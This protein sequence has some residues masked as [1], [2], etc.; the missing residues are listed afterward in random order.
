MA[1]VISASEAHE[2]YMERMKAEFHGPRYNWLLEML[3]RSSD[4]GLPVEDNCL[5]VLD[6]DG[7]AAP[8]EVLHSPASGP[9]QEG[10]LHNLKSELSPAVTRVV[11]LYYPWLYCLNFKYIGAIGYALD[12]DP[13][14]FITHF[15][16]WNRGRLDQDRRPPARLHLDTAILNF[17][18]L[19]GRRIT[20]CTVRN[21]GRS[22]I[23]FGELLLLCKLTTSSCSFARVPKGILRDHKEACG[24]T[25]DE[26]VMPARRGHIGPKD[27]SD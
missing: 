25:I 14:F 16:D 11:L 2:A 1:S 18:F 15:Q 8:R 10:F 3:S 9:L 20:A 24:T 19:K 21:I 26:D 27:T 4:W 7:N 12:L 22:P 6:F 13:W 5:Y 17:E 23:I